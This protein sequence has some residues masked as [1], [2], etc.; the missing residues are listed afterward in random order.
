[1]KTYKNEYEQIRRRVVKS[2]ENLYLKKNQ[3]ELLGGIVEVS[4]KEMQ[5]QKLIENEELA[6]KQH[7]SLEQ[8]KRTSLEMENISMEVM[9]QLDK[10]TQN[11]KG[12]DNKITG[13]NKELDQ[14]S[15]IMSR[16]MKKENRN[17]DLSGR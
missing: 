7:S 17:K 16:I 12:I 10:N 2:Q 8:A 6:W 9:R 3:D 15:T 13:M 4:N 1:M 11:M 14:S 5:R